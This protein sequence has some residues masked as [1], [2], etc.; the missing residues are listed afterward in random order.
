MKV[1]EI[2]NQFGLD[3][4]V[5]GH[6]QHPPVVAGADLGTHVGN[7]VGYRA[8]EVTH[9]H[10]LAAAGGAWRPA[11]AAALLLLALM[12]AD[13]LL[14]AVRAAVRFRDPAALLIAPVHLLRNLVWVWATL[15]WTGRRLL[16][17]RRRP[18]HSMA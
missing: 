18:S 11:A 8:Q 14:F 2:Q 12:A 17:R 13:R 4:L 15:V 9:R 16:G 5:Q 3:H 7:R 6:P 10:V 1:F